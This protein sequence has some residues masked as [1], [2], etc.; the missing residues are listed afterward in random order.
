MSWGVGAIRI[1]HSEDF[2][3]LRL[4][5]IVVTTLLSGDEGHGFASQL[6]LG[7]E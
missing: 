1:F 4:L 7:C 5:I 6:S 3:I 2:A